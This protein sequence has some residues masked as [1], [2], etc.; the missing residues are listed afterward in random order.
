MYGG[1]WQGD[2]KEKCRQTVENQTAGEV[3]PATDNNIEIKVFIGKHTGIDT[4]A[5]V[6]SIVCC[7]RCNDAQ[8]I[9]RPDFSIERNNINFDLSALSTS[10]S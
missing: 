4:N 10:L 6:F 1:P 2:G 9:Y 3:I 7:T 8:N 5:Q